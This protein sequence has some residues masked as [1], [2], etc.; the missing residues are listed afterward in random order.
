MSNHVSCANIARTI[1]IMV[2]LI[3]WPH[4]QTCTLTVVSRHD[5][6]AVTHTVSLGIRQQRGSGTQRTGRPGSFLSMAVWQTLLT[7]FVYEKSLILGKQN[8]SGCSPG[9]ATVSV[10]SRQEVLNVTTS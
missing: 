3:K 1:I 2:Y 10:C 4:V 7:V 6:P 9:R 5:R 8:V